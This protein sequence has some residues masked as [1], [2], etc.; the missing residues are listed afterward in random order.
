MLELRIYLQAMVSEEIK[1]IIL[2]STLIF[3]LAP[4]F[5][6]VYIAVY[7]QRKKK[8]I[9]EKDQMQRAFEAE[10]LNTQFEA[11]E[12]TMQ[13]IG[14]DLHD[15]VGQLLSL[16]ALTLNSIELEDTEKAKKKIL[17]A[18]DLTSRSIKEMRL[19]GKLV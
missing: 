3:L 11:Q 15:N 16:T 9:E 8:Y 10:L 7:N 4:G 14:A 13:T 5:L 19:L 6:L 18:I 2:I 1:H 17:T 12:E